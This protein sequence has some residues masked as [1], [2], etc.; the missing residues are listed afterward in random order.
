MTQPLGQYST[1]RLEPTGRFFESRRVYRLMSDFTYTSQ[2]YGI[3]TVPAGF[4][5]DFASVPRIFQLFVPVDG[6]YLEATIIHDYM[7]ENALRTKQEADA[8]LAEGMMVL[9]VKKWRQ[10]M[11]NF[12]V[13]YFG[14]GKYK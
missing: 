10:W 4:E 14:K 8:I 2:K 6:R 12:G 9:G 3:I 11:V 13:K 1:L 7:Y 5:T